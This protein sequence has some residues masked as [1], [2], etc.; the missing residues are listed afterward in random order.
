MKNKKNKL[1][2]VFSKSAADQLAKELRRASWGVA[3][4]AAGG[5]THLD[6]GLVL[7]AGAVGWMVLQVSAFLLDSIQ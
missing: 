6:A 3:L 5:G 2:F 7:V 4:T 1:K